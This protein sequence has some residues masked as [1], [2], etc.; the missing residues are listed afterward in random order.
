MI[1]YLRSQFTHAGVAEN[2]RFARKQMLDA[3]A[4]AP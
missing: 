4:S 3:Y 1:C 2:L